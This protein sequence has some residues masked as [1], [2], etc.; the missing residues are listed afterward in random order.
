MQDNV[1]MTPFEACKHYRKT[2]T[3][4]CLVRFGN[5]LI[6]A[7][8]ATPEHAIPAEEAKLIYEQ[9]MQELAQ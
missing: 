9:T 7:F 4:E 2:M 6:N 8:G 1:K 3:T 5:N